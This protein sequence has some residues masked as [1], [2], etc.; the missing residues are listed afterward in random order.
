MDQQTLREI[1]LTVADLAV[2]DQ[3]RTLCPGC[4]GGSSG[5]KSLS[6]RRTEDGAVLFQCFR[7]TCPVKGVCGGT[8][9]LAGEGHGTTAIPR[10]KVWQGV[11]T[12]DFPAAVEEWINRKWHTDVPSHWYWTE[13][14]GGRI[15][16]SVRSPQDTHRGWV[17]RSACDRPVTTKAYS[18]VDE[19]QPKASWYRT[20]TA[21]PTVLVEDI[22][23]AVRASEYVNA[24]ALLGTG[25]SPPVALEIAE[26]R[27]GR[28]IVAL[29]ADATAQAIRLA[30]KHALLWGDVS[31]AILTKDL[32]DQ[33]E[34]ELCETISRMPT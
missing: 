10:A 5:E 24:V 20:R 4:G 9:S 14:F 23:S 3:M 19:G 34:E 17:L 29:D 22:P 16:M 32:K 30:Q 26:R 25:V 1:K 12:G 2:G 6:V 31:V 18:Y 15:A 11:I 33:T 8:T 21:G 7:A 28:V 27:T 13:D